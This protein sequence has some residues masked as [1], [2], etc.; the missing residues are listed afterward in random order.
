[1]RRRAGALDSALRDVV[2]VNVGSGNAPKIEAVRSALSPYASPAL[3][4]IG[5]RVS[6]GVPEQPVGFEE[7]VVGA[8]KRAGAAVAA[9]PCDLGV[10]S[11]DGLVQLH[12]LP[13]ALVGEG[14]IA[15]LNVGAAVV[16]DAEREGFGL[17]AGFAYPPG[18]T[19]PALSGEPI[20]D[21]FDAL[22]GAYAQD[23]AEAPSAPSGRG[24]GNIG[25]LSLGVLP[26]SDYG[27]HAVLC[28]LFRFLHATLYEPGLESIPE[29]SDAPRPPASPK[30]SP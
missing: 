4:V 24:I 2:R 13:S 22:W 28:A 6:S 15:T 20:G 9:A 23:R 14:T 11:E 27:R 21:L 3:E 16:V 17:S 29:P 12:D 19:G 1:M 26:R 30:G 8:R 10:G 7:I 5:Q 25:K 18:C